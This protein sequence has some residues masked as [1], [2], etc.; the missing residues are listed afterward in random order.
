MKLVINI[1]RFLNLST[2]PQHVAFMVNNELNDI[3]PDIRDDEVF[4][5]IHQSFLNVAYGRVGEDLSME[6]VNS[7]VNALYNWGNEN[8]VKVLA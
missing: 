5:N 4:N 2:T 1:A 6:A 3:A 7:H 8:G